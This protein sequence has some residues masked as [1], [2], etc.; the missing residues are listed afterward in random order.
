MID[1]QIFSQQANQDKFPFILPDLPYADNALAP[2]MSKETFDFHHKKHH[3]AYVTN[4]NKLVESNQDLVSK[5]LEQIIIE[6][7]SNPSLKGVFNNAAQVWNH[8]FFWHS[9]KSNGGSTPSGELLR[10]I[11]NDFGSFE[12]FVSDF[13]NAGA[14][15]FGSGWVW[16]VLDGSVLKVTQTANAETP[17]TKSQKPL[18]CCDVWEHAYYI[19][20][21]N[22]RV[23]FLDVFLTNLANWDF[24]SSNLRGN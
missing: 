4:L 6:S 14:T 24:A 21:R 17:I 20:H 2:F 7:A 19:D 8:S 22:N 5:N 1:S 23:A 9:M 12:S 15:Q 16:L 10:M 3:Q 18:L 13:K 11:E